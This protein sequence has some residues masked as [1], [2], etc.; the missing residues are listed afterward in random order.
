VESAIAIQWAVGDEGVA[1]I[2]AWLP[3]HSVGDNKAEMEVIIV[4]LVGVLQE[5]VVVDVRL[6]LLPTILVGG[7]LQERVAVAN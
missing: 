5:R 1:R 3:R 2:V 6:A 7:A 4:V